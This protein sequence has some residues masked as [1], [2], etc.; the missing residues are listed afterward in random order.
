MVRLLVV[1]AVVLVG[2]L[3][4]NRLY[5][6][7]YD[8]EG[9]RQTHPEAAQQGIPQGAPM[10]VYRSREQLQQNLNQSV[11]GTQQQV[12]AIEQSLSNP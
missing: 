1:T 2:F 3:V 12:E 4:V 7:S 6:A 10:E 5:R 9:Q 8:P 11:R